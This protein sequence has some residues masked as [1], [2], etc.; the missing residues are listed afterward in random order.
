MEKYKCTLGFAVSL[1][2]DFS[3]NTVMF[4]KEIEL[5]FVPTT[6]VSYDMGEVIANFTHVKY[7]VATGEFLCVCSGH[8]VSN[9]PEFDS[10]IEHMAKIGWVRK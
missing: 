8:R 5:P 6:D 2:E 7:D 4:E 1:V 10:V 9:Q 3:S